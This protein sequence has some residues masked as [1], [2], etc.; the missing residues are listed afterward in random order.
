VAIWIPRPVYEALPYL[1]V[2]AGVAMLLAAYFL[3]PGPRGG[4]V[5]AG[6]A[7][8][9]AGLVLWMHRRDYRATQSEY[10]GRPLDE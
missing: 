10:D 2:A 4:L 7:A 9:V 6:L 5:V 8:L 3:R 1:Y